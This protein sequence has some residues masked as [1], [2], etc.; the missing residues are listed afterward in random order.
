MGA[1]GVLAAMED[2][3]E[4]DGRTAAG[5]LYHSARMSQVLVGRQ[6][7]VDIGCGNATQLL[8]LAALNPSIRFTGVDASPLMI[9]RGRERAARLRLENVDFVLEDFASLLRA[10]R[11]TYDAAICTMTLHDL[12]HAAA[13]DTGLQ[14][15][16]VCAGPAGAI[17]IED[18]A[19]L[20]APASI[21]FFVNLNAPTAADRFSALYRC[22]LAAAFTLSELREALHRWLPR[23]TLHQTFL[24]PFLTVAKTADG[25]LSGA[26]KREL[27][28]QRA[29]L[30]VANRR[31]LDD[32]RRFFK[33]GGLRNDPFV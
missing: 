3:G 22:S 21:D 2:G 31:D 11:G 5:Y 18:F 32:L 30:S 12:P 26:Q 28:L 33:L 15:M 27:T 6:H 4:I 8:Q 14:A 10:A 1:A 9:A 16:A 25:A 17:Y 20:K 19:R 23:V 29:G 13:L 7:C 24:V